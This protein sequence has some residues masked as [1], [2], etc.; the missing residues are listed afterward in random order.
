M[1][2]SKRPMPTQAFASTNTSSL[3]P[4]IKE[5]QYVHDVYE[6]IAQHFSSTRYK[7]WPVVEEFLKELEIGSIGVDVGCG[8]GKY[9]GVNR[10]VYIIGADRSSSLIE[11][12]A[13]RG[14]ETL[15]CDALN[16]PYRDECFVSI[17]DFVISIAVIH[18]FTTLERRIAATKEL[19]RIAKPGSKVLIYVWAMEQIE[20]RR[21]FDEHY[22]DVFVPWVIPADKNE[23]EEEIVYDRYYHLFKKG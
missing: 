17:F 15:I 21:K 13:S 12:S 18:H 20:S 6:K 16:L 10:N 4:T 22:Q 23:K 2:S 11:I 8:N 3:N 14:F 1:S 5:Q 19:F 9:L 7:P